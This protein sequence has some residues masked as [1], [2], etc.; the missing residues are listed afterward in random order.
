MNQITI[1]DLLE[2]AEAALESMTTADMAREIGRQV[3]IEFK[4]SG[5]SDEYQA[6]IGKKLKL[7][8]HKAHYSCDT[9]NNKEGDPFIGVGWDLGTSGC[10]SPVDSIEEAVEFFKKAIERHK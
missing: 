5:W 3:G 9:V 6:V 1:F 4:P 7:T 8:I 2:P 10:G